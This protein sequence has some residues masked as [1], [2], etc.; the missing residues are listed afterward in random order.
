MDWLA[1][2][3]D[4]EMQSFNVPRLACGTCPN[5]YGVRPQE[6]FGG[7]VSPMIVLNAAKQSEFVIRAHVKLEGRQA[8]PAAAG[9]LLTDPAKHPAV[10]DVG[11]HLH[12]LPGAA[13]AV[14][15][16]GHQVNVGA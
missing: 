7:L 8:G 6:I 4:F 13:A 2:Q 11:G 3:H 14:P 1:G 16:Q 9:Q 15:F 10:A 12:G 5:V